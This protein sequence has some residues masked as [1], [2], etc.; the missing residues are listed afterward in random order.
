MVQDS[1][2][3]LP[4]SGSTSPVHWPGHYTRLRSPS[5]TRRQTDASRPWRL[6]AYLRSASAR[7]SR[8]PSTGSHPFARCSSLWLPAALR[9][10]K[11][12]ARTTDGTR[13]TELTRSH[14]LMRKPSSCAQRSALHAATSLTPVLMATE[15][16]QRVRRL[17]AAFG[18]PHPSRCAHHPKVRN[19][20]TEA[21]MSPVRRRH[22]G[23]TW[24][25]EP[26]V[27]IE[28]TT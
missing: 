20:S 28:P 17:V 5:T 2:P 16:R 18:E 1:Q 26:P 27:G 15:Q 12:T 11:R 21:G 3:R 7:S 4:T 6:A 19:H 10:A 25:V 14:R 13:S 23:Q 24:C 9:V 22:T 8:P